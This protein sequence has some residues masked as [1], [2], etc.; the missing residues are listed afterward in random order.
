MPRVEYVIKVAK[1]AKPGVVRRRLPITPAILEKLREIWNRSPSA[2]DAKMLWAACCLCFFGFLRSG[3]VVAPVAAQFDPRSHLCFEDVQVDSRESPSLVQVR[4][5][6]SKT[7]PFRQ[8]VTLVIGKTNDCLCPVTAVLAY[9][10]ARG[11]SPGLLFT[12][13]DKRFL[14]RESFVG[15]VRAALAEAG[16][17][18]KDYAGHSFRI[19]AA[20]TAASRGLQDSLIKTLG[21]WESSAYTRYIKISPET[22]RGV[23][24]QLGV[25]PIHHP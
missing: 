15:A 24:R 14:T 20:T 1:R 8:G 9:M 2:R 5:K 4:I 19:G 23:A 12:W 17:V 18:A 25:T 7:D 13:E 10:V 3:E 11:S 21:R 16:L 22:L 6:A